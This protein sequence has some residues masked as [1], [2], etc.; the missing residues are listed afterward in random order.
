MFDSC[1]EY[2]EIEKHGRYRTRKGRGACCD[3][4]TAN[5]DRY[6]G[7]IV[8]ELLGNVFWT[9]VRLI[10]DGATRA[11]HDPRLHSSSCAYTVTTSKT[12]ISY[13][14]IFGIIWHSVQQR[15]SSKG[16][17]DGSL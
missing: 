7:A 3:I 11:R 9:S 12:N 15:F 1:K 10:M 16:R 13:G 6:G 4:T 14:T 8:D 2:D 5:A 17:L